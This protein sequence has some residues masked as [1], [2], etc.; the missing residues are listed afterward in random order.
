MWALIGM[1][2]DMNTAF[3]VRCTKSDMKTHDSG[4]FASHPDMKMV[5]F[6]A[7]GDLYWCEVRSLAH[8]PSPNVTNHWEIAI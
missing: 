4:V 3:W 2:H 6:I 7:P 8:L 5:V 1:G